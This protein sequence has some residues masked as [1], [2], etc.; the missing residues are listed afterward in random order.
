MY[1]RQEKV[2]KSLPSVADITTFLAGGGKISDN[3]AAA[4][5]MLAMKGALPAEYIAVLAKYLGL[6]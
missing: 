3:D 2:L 6:A 4:F 5:K 1:K